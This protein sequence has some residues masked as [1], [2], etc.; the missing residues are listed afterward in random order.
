MLREG[1]EE[2]YAMRGLTWT[3]VAHLM[4]FGRV[5]WFDIP[6]WESLSLCIPELTRADVAVEAHLEVWIRSAGSQDCVGAGLG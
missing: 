6:H 4:V 5:C 3:C 2:G 1:D